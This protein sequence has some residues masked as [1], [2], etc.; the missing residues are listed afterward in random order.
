MKHLLYILLTASCLTS[1]SDSNKTSDND[2]MELV[3]EP[4]KD[5][6]EAYDKKHQLGTTSCVFSF[7]DRSL[8]GIELRNARSTYQVLGI[9]TKLTGDSTHL[10]YS[11][12]QKQM[13]ALTI[14]AGDYLNQVS[15][16]T[17]SVAPNSKRNY[18]KLEP[19]AFVTEKG[20]Q[21]GISKDDLTGKLGPCYTVKDSTTHAITLN[22]RIEDE[23][24]YATYQFRNNKLERMEFGYEY[25]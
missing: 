2:R 8:S 14:H 12:D 15:I 22:Y 6:H 25:P 20:I 1:C 9:N 23:L 7:P 5:L 10:F 21:L 4:D 13:L 24:Y 16:F 18:Q 19:K 17:V 11:G 3:P